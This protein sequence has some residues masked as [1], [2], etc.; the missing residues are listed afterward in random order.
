MKKVYEAILEIMTKKSEA[1]LE[2]IQ[3]YKERCND[4]DTADIEIPIFFVLP[5]QK[6]AVAKN[7]ENLNLM[8]YAVECHIKVFINSDE[9]VK[10]RLTNYDWRVKFGKSILKKDA[11]FLEND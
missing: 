3:K 9:D 10:Q 1:A 5:M 6:D 4:D 2:M 8:C 7:E 11:C